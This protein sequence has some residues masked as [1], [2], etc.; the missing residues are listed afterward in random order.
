MRLLKTSDDEPTLNGIESISTPGLANCGLDERQSQLVRRFD[1]IA[2][3]I[4][5]AVASDSIG[6]FLARLQKVKSIL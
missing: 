5:G 6:F 2:T 4:D 1:P 3:T